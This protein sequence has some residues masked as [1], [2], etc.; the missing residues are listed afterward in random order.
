[1]TIEHWSARADAKPPAHA[2]AGEAVGVTLEEE[3]VIDRGEIVSLRDHLPVETN[4]FRARLFWL[5]PQP[6]EGGARLTARLCTQSAQV[7]VA[8]IGRVVSSAD[9]TE[10]AVHR[11]DCFDVGEVVLRSRRML[12]LDAYRDNRTTGRFV[13]VDGGEI[14]GGGVINMEGYPDQ[15]RRLTQ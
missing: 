6:L 15:R 8:E 11:L 5:N 13:L 10:R 3:I 7:E 12:A 14:V 9:L 1:K 2:A 4:V